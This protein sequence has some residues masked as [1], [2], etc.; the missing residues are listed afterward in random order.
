[1]CTEIGRFQGGRQTLLIA[2]A[3]LVLGGCASVPAVPSPSGGVDLALTGG[4][5]DPAEIA[6]AA[7]QKQSSGDYQGALMLYLEAAKVS[8]DT[9][10]WLNIGRL[11]SRLGFN[12]KALAA[13]EQ[14]VEL[15]PT[16]ARAFEGAGLI[17]LDSDARDQAER[18]LKRAVSLDGSLWRAHN[19]LGVIADL[20]ARYDD[21]IAQYQLG[22]GVHPES[23]MLRSNIGYSRYLAGDL[24]GA[25]SDFLAAISLDRSYTTAWK[26]LGL[27]YARTGRYQKAL[28]ILQATSDKSTAYNDVGYIAMLNEDFDIAESY[29]DEAIRLSPK[30]Y[31]SAVRNRELVRNR[32]KEQRLTEDPVESGDDVSDLKADAAASAEDGTPLADS[33]DPS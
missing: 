5:T 27:V 13:Y 3:L 7:A 4:M 11:Q 17:Y 19:G 21:A 16:N 6:E 30:F 1:M 31:P 25:E 18:M 23:A 29:F 20:E 33:G 2:L 9:D 12:G 24:S 15:D 22:L 10:V 8:Q 28:E 14:A 32:L 26:N